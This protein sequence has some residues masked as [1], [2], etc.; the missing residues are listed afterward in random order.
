MTIERSLLVRV[1]GSTSGVISLV[2]DIRA[3]SAR[4]RKAQPGDRSDVI[5]YETAASQLERIAAHLLSTAGAEHFEVP[6]DDRGSHGFY[7][8]TTTAE[9]P[10]A[11]RAWLAAGD[12]A[13]EVRQPFVGGATMQAARRPVREVAQ[14]WKA[15][16]DDRGRQLTGSRAVAERF[17]EQVE[18]AIQ[19]TADASMVPSGVPNSV[20][21][22]GLR[23]FV[24][25][26]ESTRAD[27][28]VM[29][30]D[31]S[32]G[33]DFPLRCLPLTETVSASWPVFRF[34]LLSIRHTEMDVEVDG[35]WLR[36]TDI[37]RPR[38]HGD[39]DRLTYEISL[40][41]L[42]RLSHDGPVVLHM[43]QTGLDTAIVGFYRAVTEH[44]LAHQNSR[45]RGGLAVVPMYF[46]QQPPGQRPDRVV[47]GYEQQSTFAVGKPW[48]L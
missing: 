5:R 27:I 46:R 35:A 16:K 7:D 42:Q 10:G 43:Y 18:A 24:I 15:P 23:D 41:Q 2:A 20:L 8:Q 6:V 13:V 25:S 29:Y 33:P 26:R 44:L 45:E 12:I 48:V 4:A 11:V 28:A 9:F 17:R 47:A 32:R 39:T 37:S 3:A 36:N 31:G 21:T 30:R 1:P 22:E 40:K 38:P 14:P 34:T 19:G